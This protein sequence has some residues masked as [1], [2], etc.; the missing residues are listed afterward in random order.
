ME[1]SLF[2]VDNGFIEAM[3]RGL[4]SGFLSPDDYRRVKGADTLED[5]RT[6]L[7]ET[8][9]G[10]FLQDEPSPIQVPT[11]TKACLE[12]LTSEFQYIQAQSVEPLT[13]FLDFLAREK[14]IDN[15]CMI[16]LGTM[17]Q[18]KPL[19]MMEKCHPMG[20]FAGIRTIM[21]DT[22]G[23]E[24]GVNKKGVDDMYRIFLV[25]TPVGKY[26]E[27]YLESVQAASGDG[28]GAVTGADSGLGDATPGVGAEQLLSKQDLEVMKQ[29]LKRA[30]L[31][32]FFE[33][34]QG[35]GGTTAEVMGHVL[36]MEADFR[37]IMVT[38]NSLHTP[39]SA[40]SEAIKERNALYPSLGYLYPD[41]IKNLKE[42]TSNLDAGVAQ[43]LHDFRTYANLFDKVK[44]FYDSEARDTQGTR[45]KSIEDLVY[46]ENVHLYEMAFEQQ[47][48]F[49]I[50]YA[51]VRLREQEVRNIHWICNMIQLNS[52]DHIDSTIVPIFEARN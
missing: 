48:H 23:T 34:C 28:D 50:F 46:G 32:D 11:I 45:G 2:N 42:L 39:L 5:V 27:Q 15:V 29:H 35:L 41:G 44:D 7:E 21:T 19:E 47:Y 13:T 3:T 25:D 20:I 37:T 38:L 26:F 31:E 14:M 49:G 9:Y 52:K 1:L 12:K 10:T 33:F 43:A 16:I 51:W 8:D 36:K 4:R 24:A 18:K 22:Y 40:D 17:N 30:W 6:A